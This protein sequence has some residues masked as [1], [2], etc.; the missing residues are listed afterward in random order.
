MFLPDV[1]LWLALA[2]ESHVHHPTA[3]AW[4]EGLTEENACRFCRMTQQGFL[5][6][7]T[8]SKAFGDEAVTMAEAWRLYDSFRTDPRVS[9]AEEPIDVESSWRTYSE[10]QT[11]SPKVWNDAYL[12]A[13]AFAGHLKLVSFDRGF[14]QYSQLDC[15]LL[16][17]P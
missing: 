4:F 6:L 7:A 1:N 2:F 11:F 13:F 12:A 17:L 8:N 14:A 16:S 9:F 15:V 3:K 10:R 5:R